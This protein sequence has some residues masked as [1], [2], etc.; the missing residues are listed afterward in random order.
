MLRDL[1]LM[2]SNSLLAS[3]HLCVLCTLFIR[4]LRDRVQIEYAIVSCLNL[5]FQHVSHRDIR[6]DSTKIKTIIK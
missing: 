6:I 4:Y 3:R 5:T 2:R 1:S